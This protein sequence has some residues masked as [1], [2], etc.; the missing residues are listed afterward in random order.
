MLTSLSLHINNR[1]T[2]P[3]PA[4]HRPRP[5]PLCPHARGPST[6]L[7]IVVLEEAAAP[8]LMPKYLVVEM[9]LECSSKERPELQATDTPLQSVA[10]HTAGVHYGPQS[11]L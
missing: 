11:Q 10:E 3:V 7:E 1:S 4:A 5:P 2:P 8:A 6:H 9:V